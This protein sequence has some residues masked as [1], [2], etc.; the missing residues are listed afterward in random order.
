MWLRLRLE[1]WMMTPLAMM[2]RQSTAACG[3][4]S[5]RVS[6]TPRVATSVRPA[7][8]L[9]KSAVPVLLAESTYSDRAV[10]PGARGAYLVG[11]DCHERSGRFQVHSRLTAH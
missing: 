9:G 4:C 10:F 1:N 11:D 6:R 5:L 3:C 8:P 2:T 7:A